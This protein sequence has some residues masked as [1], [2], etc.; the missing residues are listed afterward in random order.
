MT[1]RDGPVASSVDRLT[2]ATDAVADAHRRLGIAERDQQDAVL[3]AR[4]AGA[5]VQAI[6]DTLGRRQADVSRSY[7]PLWRNVPV[8]ARRLIRPADRDRAL[9]RILAA[10]RAV[11]AAKKAELRAVAAAR[12]AGCTWAAIG[13]AVGIT[14]RHDAANHYRGFVV[15]GPRGRWTVVA[16]PPGRVAKTTPGGVR[17]PRRRTPQEQTAAVQAQVDRYADHLSPVQLRVARL[18]LAHPDLPERALARQ[19]G[20]PPSTLQHLLERLLRHH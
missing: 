2:A 10:G 4:A 16:D 9:R 14:K 15:C 18:R 17:G 20:M 19:A 1:S 12:N 5:T 11:A 3:A 13:Q 8:P 6:A 7:G